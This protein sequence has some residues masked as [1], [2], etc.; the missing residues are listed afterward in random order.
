MRERSAAPIRSRLREL[1]NGD[2]GW[3][4]YPGTLSAT[5]PTAWATLAMSHAP[6]EAAREAVRPGRDWLLRLQRP[7]GSWPHSPG[8]PESRWATAPAALALSAFRG[9]RA[10]VA[11]AGRWLLSHRG[12][13][14]PWRLRLRYW[15]FPDQEPTEMDAGLVGWPWYP[16]TF[17][18]VEPTCYA[19][20]ALKSALADLPSGST[21]R[22]IAEG[23][24][25]LLDRVCPGGGWN[26]GNS[27]VLG[28]ELWPYA[29]TTALALIALQ[30]MGP[31]PAVT[32]GLDRLIE[33]TERNTSGLA[34]ALAVVCLRLYGR[35]ATG[36]TQ[37]LGVRYEQGR[38]LGDTRT[39]ALAAL[40]LTD[41]DPPLR[42]VPSSARMP[43]D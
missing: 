4:P 5:E 13:G 25:L 18:W 23:E 26:Y 19:L 16:G 6:S 29:D 11:A 42:V 38:F 34:T 21:R 22:R 40:A 30:D 33:L 20:L 31:D 1:Q 15:L 27:V 2:G 28:E 8:V 35:D 37:R 12:R 3:G 43:G 41:G 24:R 10:T 14:L 39:L 7:D 36:L 17:S 9:E 32:S